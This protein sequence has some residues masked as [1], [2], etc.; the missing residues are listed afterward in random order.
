MLCLHLLVLKKIKVRFKILKLV[1]PHLKEF[2]LSL[3]CLMVVIGHLAIILGHTRTNHLPW[4]WEAIALKNFFHRLTDLVH[5]DQ[6]LQVWCQKEVFLHKAD[7]K[8]TIRKIPSFKKIW[9]V[10][11]HFFLSSMLLLMTSAQLEPLLIL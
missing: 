8:G 10:C 9:T 11:I 1:W 7:L 6:I 5:Q 2:H 4:V 3:K